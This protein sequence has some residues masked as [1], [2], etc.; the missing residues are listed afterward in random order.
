MVKLVEYTFSIT[1]AKEL[2]WEVRHS[3]L[4]ELNELGDVIRAQEGGLTRKIT[5]RCKP[6]WPVDDWLAYFDE[7]IKRWR[8]LTLSQ[9]E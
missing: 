3:I 6:T 2:P 7:V 1:D 9:S 8:K 4:K 5:V